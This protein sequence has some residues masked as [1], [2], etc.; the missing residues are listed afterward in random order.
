[1]LKGTPAGYNLLVPSVKGTQVEADLLQA[2]LARK[3]GAWV[4]FYDRYERL[5]LACIRRVY[6]RYHVNCP[7]EDLEDL[8]NTVCLQ[9]VRDD[10][11]KLRQYDPERGYKISSWLGLIATNVALDALRRRG[12]STYSLDDEDGPITEQPADVPA[13]DEVSMQN[14]QIQLLNSAIARLSPMEQQFLRYYYQDGL[15]P[16]EIA[17]QMGISVNTVYSRKNKV[18]NNLLRIIRALERSAV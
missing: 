15:E 1:L 17:A 3:D 2:V 11:K 8:A 12:P 13:P 9:L 5:V 10:Y 6:Q 14:E 7:Q 16:E 18:R 4:S